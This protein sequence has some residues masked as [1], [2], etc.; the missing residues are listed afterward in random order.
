MALLGGVNSWRG[1]GDVATD[2]RFVNHG[3]LFANFFSM[4]Y[5]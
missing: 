3:T 4:N 2:F 5:I 1:L